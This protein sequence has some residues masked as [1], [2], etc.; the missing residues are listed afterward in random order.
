MVGHVVSP[1]D[2]SQTLPVGGGL[3]VLCSLQ[4]PPVNNSCKWLL[5]C[6]ARVGGFNQCASPN[7]SHHFMETVENG[8]PSLLLFSISILLVP[9]LSKNFKSIYLQSLLIQIDPHLLF[10]SSFFL[11]SISFLKKYILS[12]F[13]SENLAVENFLGF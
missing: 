1:F 11:V 7:K 9:I 13:Y 3:L 8:R 10:L 12:N 6:L 5:W 4:G 2:L